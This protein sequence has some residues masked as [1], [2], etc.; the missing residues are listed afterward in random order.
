MTTRPNAPEDPLSLDQPQRRIDR[1][2][3]KEHSRE[4]SLTDAGRQHVVGHKKPVDRRGGHDA[5]GILR[6][7]FHDER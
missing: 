4:T 2:W 7:E 1:G 6:R 5:A 3:L